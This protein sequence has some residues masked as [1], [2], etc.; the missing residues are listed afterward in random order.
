[1]AEVLG[2]GTFVVQALLVAVQHDVV[3]SD[4]AG[5][6]VGLCQEDGL[7]QVGDVLYAFAVAESTGQFEDG[8]LAHAIADDVSR[9]IAENTGPQAVL[10]VVVVSEAAQRGFNAAEHDGHVGEELAQDF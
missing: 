1:M 3:D 6:G 2:L 7:R 4:A 8:L 5:D 9:C 10:P